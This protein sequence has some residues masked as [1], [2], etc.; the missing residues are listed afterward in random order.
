[1]IILELLSL[2]ARA[3]GQVSDDYA[4]SLAADA[5]G[6]LLA[7]G[8]WSWGGQNNIFLVKTDTYGVGQWAA[9]CGGAGNEEAMAAISTSDG[10][11]AVAGLTY[12]YGTGGDMI[13][14]KLTGAGSLSW[15]RVVGGSYADEARGVAELSGGGY[16]VTGRAFVWGNG[17]DLI[18]FKLN[19]DGSYGGWMRYFGGTADDYGNWVYPTT[20][21]GFVITGGTTSYGPV[22]GDNTA[23]LLLN[24]SGLRVWFAIVSGNG[25]GS[26]IGQSV[27][28]TSDGGFVVA[29]IT[30]A[31]G[32]GGYD[33]VVFKLNSSGGLLWAR[34]I[35]GPQNDYAYSVAET[36]D[37]GLVVAGTTE[38][39]GLGSN[40]AMVVKLDSYGNLLWARTFGGF[41]AGAYDYDYGRS[42]AETPD[43]LIAFTGSTSSF[44]LNSGLYAFLVTMGQDGEYPACVSEC[45][46]VVTSISPS[47]STVSGYNNISLT[48][49]SPAVSF[50]AV[51]PN[52]VDLCLPIGTDELDLVGDQ[53]LC[54][55]VPGGLVFRVSVGM[56]LSVYSIDGGLVYSGRLQKGENRISLARG[57]YLWMA[58]GRKGRGVVR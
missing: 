24:S 33:F 36:Q 19:P 35:G 51:E 39:Y 22:G 17:Y 26:L 42:V 15:A 25:S 46:P 48:I 16:V 21:G 49:S 53:V 47:V 32:S 18:F 27:I 5:S 12:T 23:V 4:Y 38:S 41:E 34:A 1:M 10:G 2:F 58:N 40:E 8:T 56:D 31:F 37:N 44:G 30:N 52:Q 50:S 57:V 6:F 55:S 20:D 28:Q 9:V 43:G 29:G 54:L 45:G 13:L 11:Y 3:Y 14:L 7:G